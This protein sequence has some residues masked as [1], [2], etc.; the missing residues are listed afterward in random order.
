MNLVGF[1][2]ERSID[3][4]LPYTMANG[5]TPPTWILACYIRMP[6]L[7]RWVGKQFLV[8]AVKP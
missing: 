3:R 2:V 4:F 8:V 6:F 5:F 7:W 1:R